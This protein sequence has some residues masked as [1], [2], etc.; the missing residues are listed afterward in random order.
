MAR[1]VSGNQIHYEYGIHYIENADEKNRI[2]CRKLRYP[3]SEN[4]SCKRGQI[5]MVQFH[6]V[7]Q[8]PQR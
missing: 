3:W 6:R 2:G 4:T 7:E 5:M 8:T 1:F